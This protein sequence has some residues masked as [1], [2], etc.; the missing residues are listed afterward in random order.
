MT[1]LI[2]N[3]TTRMDTNDTPDGKATVCKQ[4]NH[5]HKEADG[6][7]ACGCKAKAE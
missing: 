5:E 1:V 4:C 2:G 6:S 3:N 7:C